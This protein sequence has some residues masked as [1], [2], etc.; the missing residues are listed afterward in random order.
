[1]NNRPISLGDKIRFKKPNK[2]ITPNTKLS[3]GKYI[4]KIAKKVN[5]P[6]YF[7]WLAANTDYS[8]H[9]SLTK[10]NSEERNIV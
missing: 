8:V 4:G 7:I 1:M 10:I 3:F 6:K 5:D 2:D 9:H